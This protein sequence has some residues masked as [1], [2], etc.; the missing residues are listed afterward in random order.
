MK[1]IILSF[2]IKKYN[3]KNMKGD[4]TALYDAGLVSEIKDLYDIRNEI[5]KMIKYLKKEKNNIT[6]HI[7]NKIWVKK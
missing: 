1:K 4:K 6:L 3:D 2:K 5:K 7:G